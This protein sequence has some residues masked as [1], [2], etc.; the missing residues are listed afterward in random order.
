MITD[1]R[2]GGRGKDDTTQLDIPDTPAPVFAARALK[3]AIFGESAAARNAAAANDQ[4]R[5]KQ[6]K[7]NANEAT[8]SDMKSPNKPTSI[9]LTPGTGTA[10]RKRVSFGRDVKAGNSTEPGSVATNPDGTRRKTTL[11]QALE[12]SRSARSKPAAQGDEQQNKEQSR[13]PVQAPPPKI[14]GADSESEWE[15][16]ICNHDV[17]VDLNEPHSNSG[18]YWK[19]EFTR[20]HE[21]AR[22]EMDKLVRYKHMAKSYAKKKDAEAINLTQRLKEEQDKVLNME[23]KITEMAAQIADKRRQGTGTDSDSATLMKDLAK[24]TN[25]AVQYR[26]QVRGL[27]AILKGQQDEAGPGRP[28]RGRINTSPRTEKTILEVNRELRRARAELRQMDSLREENKRLRSDLGASQQEAKQLAEENR[29]TGGHPA[30]APAPEPSRPQR[31]EKQ[32][33]EARDELRQRDAEI[34]RMGR[35]YETLKRDAKARTGE[36]MQVLQEKNDK[37][38]QLE[39]EI[40]ALR[41]E[42]ASGGGDRHGSLDTALAEHGRITRDL[43]SGIESLGRP[44]GREAAARR[45][46]TTTTTKTRQRSASVEDLTLDMTQRS[47]FGDKDRA[48][49]GRPTA[50]S[51]EIQPYPDDWTNN[52]LQEV[53]DQLKREKAEYTGAAGRDRDTFTD[54]LDLDLAPLATSVAAKTYDHGYQP[55]SFPSRRVMSDRV[56]ESTPAAAARRHRPSGQQYDKEDVIGHHQQKQQRLAVS[57]GAAALAPTTTTTTTTASVR[58]AAA[59]PLYTMHGGR[60]GVAA[61][62]AAAAAALLRPGRNT[63][64]PN[65]NPS[66]AYVPPAVSE[67]NDAQDIDLFKDRFARLGG[68][69]GG[70]GGAAGTGVGA[71]AGGPSSASGKPVDTTAAPA[72]AGAP[73]AG[74][75]AATANSSRCTLPADRQAAARARLEQKRLERQ[76]EKM[77]R[78]RAGGGGGR[79]FSTA[80]DKE[81]LVPC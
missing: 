53:E 65:P 40:K 9:L 55:S 24:Q 13:E 48:E 38:A 7:K 81:N 25:L 59:P 79:A 11:Q 17:T 62:T 77:E 15:D 41:A 44:Y 72:R 51:D 28:E 78:E 63:L 50:N 34:R 5:N 30:P 68:G 14:D 49:E 67:D 3:N 73:G 29:K 71:G 8:S 75:G 2:W 31:L 23:Q 69:G 64:N 1:I 26:D 57:G 10:K 16:D 46:R 36:A 52:S 33:R 35:E 20:Y 6:T 60:D 80:A 54:T 56:N 18:K 42:K 66:S 37:I 76:R 12:N 45:R 47:L 21:E 43:K 61:S 39:R 27:E 4:K 19:S 70:G 22:A 74:A 32:L 58:A